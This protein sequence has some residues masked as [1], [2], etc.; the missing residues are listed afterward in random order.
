ML[1]SL[2]KNSY[3]E[4]EIFG[5]DLGELIFLTKDVKFYFYNKFLL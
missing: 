2:I 4:I 1:F 3:E 5:V